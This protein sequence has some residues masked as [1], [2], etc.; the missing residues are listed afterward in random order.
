MTKSPNRSWLYRKQG[1]LVSQNSAYIN[2]ILF[3]LNQHR[4]DHCLN[5]RYKRGSHKEEKFLAIKLAT[6]KAVYRINL[7]ILE[8]NSSSQVVTARLPKRQSSILPIS[9]LSF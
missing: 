1:K 2:F 5:I 3:L 9:K 4:P 6:M 7:F 8:T